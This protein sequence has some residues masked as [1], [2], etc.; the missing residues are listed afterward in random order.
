M[1]VME[2]ER[3][4]I[5]IP[6]LTW[7]N[8]SM[9][10]DLGDTEWMQGIGKHCMNTRDWKAL[11]MNARGIEWM[12]VGARGPEWMSVYLNSWAKQTNARLC[13]QYLSVCRGRLY[14]VL[15]MNFKKLFHEE[16]LVAICEQPYTPNDN[17]DL[18]FFQLWAPG[19]L[20]EYFPEQWP[21]AS[22]KR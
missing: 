14:K 20:R 15:Y 12:Q 17:N 3:H 7:W 2:D 18:P 10:E 11:W 6:N 16:N 21:G 4:L 13:N 1:N 8:Q 9:R 22:H 5:S 19:W